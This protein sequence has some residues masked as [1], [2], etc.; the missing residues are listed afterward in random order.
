MSLE[1]LM[2]HLE[3]SDED[4]RALQTAADQQLTE[5]TNK[6][7]VISLSAKPEVHTNPKP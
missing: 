1:N 2:G 5:E 3:P 4:L 7:G 6:I